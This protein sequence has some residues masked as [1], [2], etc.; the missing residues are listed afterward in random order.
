MDN[1]Y[2]NVLPS[3]MKKTWNKSCWLFLFLKYSLV[4]D[5]IHHLTMGI[6]LI[7][8]TFHDRQ[9]FEMGIEDELQNGMRNIGDEVV[10]E[11]VLEEIIREVAV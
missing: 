5:R 2:V 9:E 7:N 6:D 3:I 1:S 11:V 8:R 4:L 10:L